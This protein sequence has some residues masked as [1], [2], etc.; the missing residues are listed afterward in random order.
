MTPEGLATLCAAALPHEGLT[1]DD[2]ATCCFGPGSEVLGDD[3]G[4]VVL[5]VKRF[6]EHA[7][8]GIVLLAVRPDAQGRGL[9]RALVDTAAERA[10]VQGAAD[11]HLGT[12]LPR[13]VWPGVDFAFTGALALFEAT[14]FEPYGAEFN[15]AIDTGFRQAPP[16]GVDI[17][18]ESEEGAADLARAEFPHWEDEVVRAVARGTCFVARV[19]DATL[20]FGCHSVNRRG[21]IGPMATDP[22]HRYGGMG[23]VLLGAVCADLADGG[24]ATADIAWVGPAGFYARAGA[25]VSRVFRTARRRL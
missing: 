22:N 17:V 10:R 7:R 15:M 8:A 3:R 21:W 5:T 12:A 19:N 6:G 18:R 11:L 2:V 1:I 4:A 9:G 16:A 14:G 13:Y 20:G 24:T 25:H 23:Y